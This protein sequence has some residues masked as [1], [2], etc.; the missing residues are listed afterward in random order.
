MDTNERNKIIAKIY[1]DNVED[2]KEVV[3]E[4][5]LTR[6]VDRVKYLSIAYNTLTRIECQVGSIPVIEIDKKYGDVVSV[7]KDGKSIIKQRAGDRAFFDE[8][9]ITSLATVSN[10]EVMQRSYSIIDRITE[11]VPRELA[12]EIDKTF[13]NA[14]KNKSKKNWFPRKLTVDLLKNS[15]LK[16]TNS[17][18]ILV[19]NETYNQG[20]N[21]FDTYVNETDMKLF[22][23]EDVPKKVVYILPENLGFL[24][25]RTNEGTS[26][27]VVFNADNFV[28]DCEDSYGWLFNS[29]LGI[30]ISGPTSIELKIR[31]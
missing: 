7:G 6:V 4:N 12:E 18:T 14:V 24:G 29:I 20:K 9:L 23:S 26:D 8:F 16:V 15:S 30:I 13:L 2:R 1:S 28:Q 5:F 11:K 22:I 27:V 25:V 17:K 19:S 21:I 3:V 10:L 31:F